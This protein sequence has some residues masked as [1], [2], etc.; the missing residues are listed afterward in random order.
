MWLFASTA[1]A[2]DRLWILPGDVY[3]EVSYL[4]GGLLR[5]FCVNNHLGDGWA[6]R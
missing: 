1:Y 4:G 3:K 5:P 6:Q 2:D